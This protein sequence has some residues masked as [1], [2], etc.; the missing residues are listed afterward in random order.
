MRRLE[1][2]RSTRHALATVV[3][4]LA[5]LAASA[6]LPASTATTPAGPARGVLLSPDSLHRPRLDAPRSAPA[7]PDTGGSRRSPGSRTGSQSD[8][9]NS[10]IAC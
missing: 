10:T 3:A 1:T 6:A 5:G 8:F 9:R 7:A 4:L 2:I